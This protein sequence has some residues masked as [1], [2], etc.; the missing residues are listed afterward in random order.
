MAFVLGIF[1]YIVITVLRFCHMLTCIRIDVHHPEIWDSKS[2]SSLVMM[3]K[4]KIYIMLWGNVRSQGSTVGIAT[5]YGLDDRGVEV[6]VPVGSRIF[7]SPH[8]PD[9]L[10]GPPRLL[11]N[12][13]WGLFPRG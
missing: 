4:L 2:R 6:R 12:G 10:W 13:Y 7:S 9:G 1:V 11:S 3:V 8:C 5:G